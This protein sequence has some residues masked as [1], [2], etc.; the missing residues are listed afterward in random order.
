MK[1]IILTDF[2]SPRKELVNAEYITNVMPD[3]KHGGSKIYTIGGTETFV[4]E[5]PEEVYELIE[6]QPIEAPKYR[7]SFMPSAL[8]HE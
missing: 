1:I 6:G 4:R 7:S 5:T 8:K 3:D 2:Q